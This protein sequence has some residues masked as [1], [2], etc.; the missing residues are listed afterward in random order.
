MTGKAV[1]EVSTADIS[2]ALDNSSEVAGNTEPST[3]DNS[4]NAAE[5]EPNM[6]TQTEN[7]SGNQEAADKAHGSR[8]DST[9]ADGSRCDST[10]ASGAGAD[11]TTPKFDNLE[12]ALKGYANLE[13]KLGEQSSELGELRKKADLAEQL[14]KEQLQI[15][16]SYGFE[17]VEAFKNA[18]AEQEYDQ[19][20]AAY[21]ADQYAQ[22]ID[23][24]G[25]PDEMQKLL[26]SY[27]QNPTAETLELIEADFPVEIVKQV[28]GKMAV[29]KGQLQ[30][31]QQEAQMERLRESAKAYLDEN[32][33]KYAKEFENEAFSALYGEAFRAYGCDLDTD[34]FVKLM[35][36]YANSVEKAA[37]VNNG[38]IKENQ[39]V[40]S[41]I[42]GLV[43]NNAQ[44]PSFTDKDIDK[45]S[46]KEL[47]ANIRKYI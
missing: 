47:A 29:A 40:T 23:K 13:K 4:D 2:A 11:S 10:T 24:C 22:F 14:Q 44:Q 46:D 43:G 1:T 19:K 31:A 34:K 27:R 18:Q 15:A 9:T 32:V 3:G 25:F 6:Q 45:M 7:A 28:A 17:S 20:L 36:D 37:V 42:A 33:N 21:E 38:I 16:Q 39:D 35:R 30:A 8:C 26:M 41:E 12:A 5:Q